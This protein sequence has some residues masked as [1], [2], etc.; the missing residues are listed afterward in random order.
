[1]FARFNER[2]A[3]EWSGDNWIKADL[4]KPMLHINPEKTNFYDFTIDDFAMM[5]YESMKPQ[6]KFDLGI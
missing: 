4:P 1:M 5:D 2:E 6:L 3:A